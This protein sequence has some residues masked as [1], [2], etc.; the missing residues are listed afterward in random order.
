MPWTYGD[1]QRDP[2][3]ADRARGRLGMGQPGQLD[4]ARPGPQER[5]AHLVR[6]ASSGSTTVDIGAEATAWAGEAGAA[7]CV[8]PFAL[9][10][11]VGR[12]L[13][14]PEPQPDLGRGRALEVRP[15]RAGTVTPA[16]AVR[17]APQDE[18]GYGSGWRDGEVD[19]QGQRYNRDYGRRVD[20]QGHESGRRLRAVVLP[21]LGAPSGR[22]P[23]GLRR[24]SP[25]GGNGG[26]AATAVETAAATAPRIS[27]TRGTGTGTGGSSGSRSARTWA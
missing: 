4:R 15:R 6:H 24:D 10:G 19:A 20:H 7:Q 16:T 22:R 8:K 3:P 2:K 12:D 25:G 17:A 1:E 14:R 5:R 27:P 23:A 21:A 9:P 13:G 26:G 11:P 18:T